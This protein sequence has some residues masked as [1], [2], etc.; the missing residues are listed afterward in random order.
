MG[1]DPRRLKSG[2]K[3]EVYGWRD[4][5][6]SRD[7]ALQKRSGIFEY[8][9]RPGYVIR[10]DHGYTE[11]WNERDLGYGLNRQWVPQ[12]YKPGRDR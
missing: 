3:I 5:G 1:Y 12:G 10:F 9:A 8:R 4:E 7:N 2:E 6:K 11:C